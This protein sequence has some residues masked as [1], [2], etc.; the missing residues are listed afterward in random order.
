VA[1]DT[2]P[3]CDAPVALLRRREPRPEHDLRRARITTLRTRAAQIARG[4]LTPRHLKE[5]AL[6]MC[7]TC[8]DI[9]AGA[10]PLGRAEI[11]RR[12]H[13]EVRRLERRAG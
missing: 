12:I 5:Q 8:Q 2:C 3:L 1:P 11:E 10:P 7:R 13:D 9:L 4:T 6:W